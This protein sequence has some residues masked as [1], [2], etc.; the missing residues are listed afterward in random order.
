MDTS[1]LY[2]GDENLDDTTQEQYDNWIVSSSGDEDDWS[3]VE[4]ELFGDC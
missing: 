1:N 3:T 2:Y 4:G